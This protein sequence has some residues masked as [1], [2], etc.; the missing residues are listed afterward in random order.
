[1][2][3]AL[4]PKSQA[5]VTEMWQQLSQT[6]K[7]GLVAL[8]IAALT[9]LIFF[10]TWAQTPDYSVA[11]TGLKS[12]DGAAIVEYLKE[13]NISY[14]ITDG[15]S[16]ISVPSNQVYEVRLALA[17]KGLPG[18]GAVGMEL[19]DNTNLGMTDFIQQVN[20]QRALEGELARTISSL[21]AVRSARVHI[22]IPQPSLFSEEQ[23]PTTA[24]VVVELESGE[25]LNR[26]QVRAISH[27]VS[28]AVE[29]L[30]PE[31]LTIVDVDGN[32]LVDGTM[33]EYTSSVAASTSQLDTQRSFERDL[34]L[35][36][37]SM[38]QNVLGPDKAVVR[39]NSKMN[40]D[41]IETESETYSPVK[42]GAFCAARG[43]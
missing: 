43:R 32:V 11:F 18:E 41:Q 3:Q 20:Y 23:Q 12:D 40:W 8:V 25:Q 13:N 24:S 42:K 10:V 26:E 19:F 39:V 29:G 22:V 38:L 36:I 16:T 1:M 15:G 27:L 14:E 21:T 31:S 5:E 33:S 34:E 4:V 35:R 17:A 6:R 9:G 37:E 7:I 30:S 2:S 28:S